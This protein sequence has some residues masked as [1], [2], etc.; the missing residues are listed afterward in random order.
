MCSIF[1]GTWLFDLMDLLSI[2]GDG[3]SQELYERLTLTAGAH[4]DFDFRS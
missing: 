1:L 2:V 3:R 4:H